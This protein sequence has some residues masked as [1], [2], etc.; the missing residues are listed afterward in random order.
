MVE[1]ARGVGT[2]GCSR[3]F[4]CFKRHNDNAPERTTSVSP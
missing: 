3:I 1:T 2:G 4:F